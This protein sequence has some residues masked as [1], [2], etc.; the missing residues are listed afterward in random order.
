MT[1]LSAHGGAEVTGKFH[2]SRGSDR[3]IGW[4][5][6]HGADDAGLVSQSPMAGNVCG[7]AGAHGRCIE[8]AMVMEAGPD[9]QAR[10]GRFKTEVKDVLRGQKIV[11]EGQF[12][13]SR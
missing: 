6:Q 8:T 2:R 12:N 13:L 5:W 11:I 4:P 10:I 9:S 7:G 1:S 3:G